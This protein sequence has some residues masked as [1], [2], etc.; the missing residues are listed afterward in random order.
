[1]IAT[2]RLTLR[3]ARPDDLEDLHAI[4]SDPRAMRY[5]DRPAHENRDQTR[6]FLNHFIHGPPD[7]REE[8][9]LDLEGRAIGKAGVWAMPELGFILNPRHWGRGFATEALQAI[10]PR[11][12]AKFPDEPVLTA[13]IDP[14]N[15]ASRRVLTRLGFRQTG[16]AEKNFLYGGTE[17][18]DTAYFALP[19]PGSVPPPADA[20]TAR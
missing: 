18:C 14:R 12:F 17:W 20:G 6:A 16:F 1:M 3:P 19:R 11:A 10:L 9:I 13:E 15:T 5:W 8:Y 7:T 4:F 2:A